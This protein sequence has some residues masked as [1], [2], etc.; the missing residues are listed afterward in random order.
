MVLLN[1]CNTEKIARIKMGAK[2]EKPAHPFVVLSKDNST[3]EATTVA[4]SGTTIIA[5]GKKYKDYDVSIYSNGMNTFANVGDE[6]FAREIFTGDISGYLYQ[7]TKRVREHIAGPQGYSGPGG[8]TTYTTRTFKNYY[9]HKSGAPDFVKFKTKNVIKMIPEGDPGYKY[10]E[11]C[12]K[13]RTM[14]ILSKIVG[15]G[16]A[17]IAC[18]YA[19]TTPEGKSM[20]T[21][22]VI[23]G[24]LYLASTVTFLI[25]DDRE[26]ENLH[27]A[28][29]AHNGLTYKD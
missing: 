24:A 28:V 23:C 13:N 4:K 27:K 17:G 12:K 16:A 25:S 11:V 3:I 7:Y 8:V 9:V 10:L 15:F 20:T 21:P 5:D 19:L 1:S 2:S 29:G 18:K 22:L 6:R 26:E 14:K